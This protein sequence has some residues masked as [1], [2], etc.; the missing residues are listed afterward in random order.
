M[1]LNLI[2]MLLHLLGQQL[3]QNA[4]P[5]PVVPE[6][7]YVNYIVQHDEKVYAVSVSSDRY[8]AAMRMRHLN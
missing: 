7:T 3:Q 4:A 1:N 2:H 8:L 6:G 5:E